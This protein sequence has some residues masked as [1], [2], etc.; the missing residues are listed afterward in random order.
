MYLPMKARRT[1]IYLRPDQLTKLKAL[2]RKT[3]ATAS[4][5]IRRAVD[6]YLKKN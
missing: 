5:S 4:E 6:A 2:Q 3:G 1:N